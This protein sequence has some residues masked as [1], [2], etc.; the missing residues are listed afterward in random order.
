MSDLPLVSII[1]PTYNQRESYLRECIESAIGQTYEN[2]EIIISDNHSTNNAPE[3]IAEYAAQNKKIRVIKPPEFLNMSGSFFYVFPQAAGKYIC[4]L[5]SDDILMP[6]CVEIL[7]TKME[8]NEETVFAHGHALY[9]KNDHTSSVHW[10]YF[11]HSGVY[12]LNKKT[13]DLLLRFQYICFGGC[14]VRNTVREKLMHPCGSEDP[15][16][17]YS[18]DILYSILLFNPGKVYYHNDVLLKFRWENDTRNSRLP[19][20]VSDALFIWDF[21]KANKEIAARFAAVGADIDC[22][23][24]RQFLLFHKDLLIQFGKGHFDL[25]VFKTVLKELEAFNIKTPF[26]YQFLDAANMIFPKLSIGIFR[27]LKAIRR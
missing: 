12:G 22:Y 20:M 19:F 24:K 13:A 18:L 11:E 16:I 23:K 4:Y 7:A 14:L 5:S 27:L 17:T 25:Q 10:N 6:S 26:R 1:I 15:N 2:I 21:L 9:F 8:E 3:I